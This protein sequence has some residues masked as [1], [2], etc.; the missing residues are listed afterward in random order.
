M[1]KILCLRPLLLAFAVLAGC[2]SFCILSAVS[3]P[4]NNRQQELKNVKW[5]SG[6]ND[7]GVSLQFTVLDFNNL[8]YGTIQ[9]GDIKKEIA[10]DW[11]NT[12]FHLSEVDLYGRVKQTYTSGGVYDII[13]DD[14]VVLDFGADY[15]FD[16][17]LKDKKI[18][19][20]ANAVN[21]QNYGVR[22]RNE[23]CLE[24]E[25]KNLQLFT[26]Q[27]MRRFSVGTYGEKNVVSY[28]LDNE[29]FEIYELIDGVQQEELLMY[30]ACESNVNILTLDYVT[31]GG[32]SGTVTLNSREIDYWEIPQ[33]TWYPAESAN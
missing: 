26:Y 20:T 28:W 14:E 24:T 6:A 3:C 18:T 31:G 21:P 7:Y 17:A 23:V 12:G 27:T 8:Y 32:E 2:L 13:K 9:Y 16:G 22:D 1:K 33:E 30:G 4:Q 10:F 29:K 25:D 19:V 15:L 11:W 5:Q